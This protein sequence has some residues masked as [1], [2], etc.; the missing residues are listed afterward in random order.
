M[1]CLF[2]KGIP[3]DGKATALLSTSGQIGVY[4]EG[5][6]NAFHNLEDFPGE[7]LSL[8]L[9]G[10]TKPQPF[11]L[12]SAP[13]VIF[14]E[15]SDPDT[16]TNAL[17]RC[18]FLLDK[19]QKP[20]INK[21]KAIL[22]TRRDTN[23]LRLKDVDG[24]IMPKTVQIQPK[25]PKDVALAVEEA[26]MDYPV[27]FREAGLHGGRSAVRID[28]ADDIKSAMH[29]YALDGRPYYL[30][31]FHDFRSPDDLYRKY[32]IVVVN[33]EPVL[34]HLIISDSWL[35]HSASRQFMDDKPA[36]QEEEEKTLADFNVNGQIDD[37]LKTLI[38]EID[39]IMELDYYGIDCN[40]SKSGELTV[41]EI[42]ANMNILI[43]TSPSPNKWDTPIATI[44]DK[45]NTLITQKA[46]S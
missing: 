34:R 7:K 22:L 23:Y 46:Q 29:A 10:G 18:I 25:K 41:F 44:K 3:N 32:R 28:S 8:A 16:H 24:I 36:L 11:K 19:L 43:N 38:G 1:N 5:N 26:G 6:C 30:T 33:G 2:L 45:L 9:S 42:N 17:K 13:D 37:R 27:I 35:I 12:A 14:N 40:I 4:L 20:V 15:I 21:P 39:R 31:A